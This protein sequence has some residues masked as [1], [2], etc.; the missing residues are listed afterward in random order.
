M[1]QTIHERDSGKASDVECRAAHPCGLRHLSTEDEKEK[2]DAETLGVV[3]PKVVTVNASS[4]P[5]F[6]HLFL[7][8]NQRYFI[9][10]QD[11]C[12]PGANS[13]GGGRSS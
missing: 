9:R 12:V 3:L 1:D 4:S 8:T 6:L 10:F 13:G 11:G 5:L 7:I 2:E